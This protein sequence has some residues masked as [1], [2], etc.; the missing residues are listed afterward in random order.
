VDKDLH[1]NK[2]GNQPSTSVQTI[3]RASSI[4]RCIKEN[5][6]ELGVTQ[7]SRLVGIHKSTVSRLLAALQREGFVKQNSET[8]K[9]RL[10]LGLLD[11]AG[12]VLERLELQ[13]VT[14]SSLRTLSTKTQ[15]TI[16][17][18]ILDGNECVNI[19]NVPSSKSI[20]HTGRLGRRTPLHCTSTGKTFLAY[21]TPA[22]RNSLLSKK[23]Q[24]CTANTIV[25]RRIFDKSLEQIRKQGYAVAHEEYE[26]G[27]SAIAAPIFDHTKRVTAAVSISGPSYRMGPGQIEKFIEPLK[28]AAKYISDQLGYIEPD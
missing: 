25:D 2:G 10:G 28:D 27:L 22:E 23:L 1:I 21:L 16:N 12:S 13:H 3:Q 11:L 14:L 26:E 4:L 18:T 9:W 8:G 20:Q 17:V 24:P 19:V 7:I 15:E 6:T 5:N